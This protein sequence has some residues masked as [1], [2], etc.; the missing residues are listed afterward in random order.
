MSQPPSAGAVA[1]DRDFAEGG[2]YLA[3]RGSFF[4]AV[5][6]DAQT[7][8]KALIGRRR[9][10]AEVVR[11]AE[12]GAATSREGEADGP[13]GVDGGHRG[14]LSSEGCSAPKSVAPGINAIFR[15]KPMMH[16][17]R[18]AAAGEPES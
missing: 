17:L 12:G 4:L 3:A 6:S 1:R 15:I 7:S 13:A 10:A 16:V 18:P 11:A 9:S 14:R 8:T 5:A 2:S